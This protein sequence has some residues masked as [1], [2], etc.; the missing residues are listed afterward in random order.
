MQDHLNLSSLCVVVV[1]VDEMERKSFFMGL[2]MCNCILHIYLNLST[3]V[4]RKYL[5]IAIKVEKCI[6]DNV[7]GISEESS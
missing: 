2:Q 1:L 7:C 4:F 3:P 6:S 5:G